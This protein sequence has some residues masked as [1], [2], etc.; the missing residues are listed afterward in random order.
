MKTDNSEHVTWSEGFLQEIK[1]GMDVKV[2][3]RYYG[4][5]AIAGGHGRWIAQE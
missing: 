4:V 5:L 2:A 3:A 1:H